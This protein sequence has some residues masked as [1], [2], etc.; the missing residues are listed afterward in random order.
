MQKKCIFF[1]V[2]GNSEILLG[3]ADIELFSILNINCNTISRGKEE[4]G[5]NC[6]MRKDSL[7]SAELSS[8]MQT[9]A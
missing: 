9:Q 3:M 1:V 2:P 8:A 4:K 7:L 5:V 6:N